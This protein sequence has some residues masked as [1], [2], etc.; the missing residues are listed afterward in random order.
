MTEEDKKYCAMIRFGDS[1]INFVDYGSNS[2]RNWFSLSQT[3]VP[4]ELREKGYDAW[5]WL[6][7]YELAFKG[8]R[9]SSVG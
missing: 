3:A 8:A 2:V 4:K 6:E 5:N 1:N 9:A 7:Y